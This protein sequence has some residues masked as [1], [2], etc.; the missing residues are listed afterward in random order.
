ML[1][2]S[3]NTNLK[4]EKYLFFLETLPRHHF[5]FFFF[6]FFS[7][8][9]ETATTPGL[10]LQGC[11]RLDDI[12]KKFIEKKR[13]RRRI[14]L[15]SSSFRYIYNM[16]KNTQNKKQFLKIFLK[17]YKPSQSLYLCG[18]PGFFRRCRRPLRGLQNQ[19]ERLKSMPKKVCT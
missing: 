12:Y 10:H 9:I 1:R 17:I 16:Q 8:K 5:L 11:S 3:K 18:F 6:S 2:Q 7:T 14:R 15:T 13:N 4:R 19:K